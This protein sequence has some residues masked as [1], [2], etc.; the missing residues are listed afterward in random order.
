VPKTRNSPKIPFF[1]EKSQLH[2]QMISK[3]AVICFKTKGLQHFFETEA[4]LIP[5]VYTNSLKNAIF[6]QNSPIFCKKSAL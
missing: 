2:Q 1:Y 5:S 6:N 3:K 4:N